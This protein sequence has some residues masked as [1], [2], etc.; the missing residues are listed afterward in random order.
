MK[1][2]I[3]IMLSLML[4]CAL[5]LSGT[6]LPAGA[7]MALPWQIGDMD[8]DNTITIMDATRIQRLLA[9]FGE[10]TEL[11]ET[12]GDAD[13]SGRMT[14]LDATCIQRYL[15]ELPSSYRY[16]ELTD[17]YV[18]DTGFHS[19]AEIYAPGAD[20][21]RGIGYV[22]M[23]IDFTLRLKWG[24]PPQRWRLSVN[25]TTVWEREANGAREF[26]FSYT[27]DSEGSYEVTV[28]VT[29]KYGVSKTFRQQIDVQTLPDDG[30]PVIM[31]AAYFDQTW[32]SSGDGDLTITAAGGT[33]PYTYHYT[34]YYA[35]S[36]IDDFPIGGGSSLGGDPDEPAYALVG[37]SV[38]TG[39]ISKDT[40]NPQQMMSR[41]DCD[42]N[43][44]LYICVTVRDAQG[45]TSPSV[46]V[47][48]YQYMVFV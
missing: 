2:T 19:T 27:F 41:Y 30:R 47:V 13:G 15:A 39:F 29:C 18:G 48:C 38:S 46:T 23:P 34:V 10:I 1:K 32:M 25:G 42:A 4:C 36:P 45:R 14:I 5:V 8:H 17:Y 22:G 9:G 28:L 11:E 37:K 7:A 16:R 35:Q 20:S 40:I 6:A 21:T 3:G 31:G 12:L 26:T 43:E 33:A 44:N 24:N